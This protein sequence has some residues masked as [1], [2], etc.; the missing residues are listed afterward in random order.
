MSTAGNGRTGTEQ[1]AQQELE[2][3]LQ[4][5][6]DAL[7]QAAPPE[8]PPVD[9]A[10]VPGLSPLYSM[11][12]DLRRFLLGLSQGDLQQ[13]LAHKGYLPGVLKSFQS[14]LSHLTWQTQMIA[15]G[16]FSQ[17]VDFLGEFSQAFNSMVVRLH[18]SIEAL[19]QSE[20]RYR[21]LAE[22]S[23][24]IIWRIDADH[25]FIYASPAD[26]RMRG[27]NH[28]EILGQPVWSAMHPDFVALMQE[29]CQ[30]YLAAIADVADPAPL[31]VEVPLLR[32]DGGSIWAEIL[33]NPVRETDGSIRGF[34]LVARDISLRMEL[35]AELKRLAATDPLTGIN[36]RRHFLQHAQQELQRS[37]RYGL[38]MALL[39]LDIDKFKNVNDTFGH[40]TGDTVLKAVVEA[41]SLNLRHV[42][43]FGRLGGEEFA[44][45]LPQ[46]DM[47]GALTMAERLRQAVEALEIPG[48]GD[49]TPIRVTISLGLSALRP[50]EDLDALMR[51]ADAALYRAKNEGR[52][53]TCVCNVP[54]DASA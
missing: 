9:L 49:D 21:F 40:A 3:V 5:L 51:R 8:A 23:A 27:F 10:H 7:Q 19:R 44:T 36:N 43:I 47:D 18:D 37:E 32:K 35:E 34:H 1:D 28:K 42:D 53:R 16:D 22:N 30:D 6:S 17:R 2:R 24:D 45:L 20:E 33:S 54:E 14:N 38:P 41:C 39:M 11:V 50:G 26:E 15:E 12:M 31:R 13:Q 52:N 46:T 4:V 48:N 25:R 29:R